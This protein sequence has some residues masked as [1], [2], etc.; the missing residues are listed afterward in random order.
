[1]IQSDNLDAYSLGHP[2]LFATSSG[3]TNFDEKGSLGL[4]QDGG[5]ERHVLFEVQLQLVPLWYLLAY[6]T[7]SYIVCACV[8]VVDMVKLQKHTGTYSSCDPKT[9]VIQK[10][11][12]FQGG[13]GLTYFPAFIM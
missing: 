3:F 8:C 1:M 10:L 9:G 12:D 13:Y 5:P 2:R 4:I 6:L 7:L 11:S